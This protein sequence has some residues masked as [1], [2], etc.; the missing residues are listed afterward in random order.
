MAVL[1]ATHLLRVSRVGGGTSIQDRQNIHEH[2][3]NNFTKSKPP[4][5][6]VSPIVSHHCAP[7]CYCHVLLAAGQCNEGLPAMQ[8]TGSA[9]NRPDVF[10]R[11]PMKSIILTV[12]S[13]SIDALRP[14]RANMS[15]QLSMCADCLQEV[16]GGAGQG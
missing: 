1:C 7:Q 4:M 9:K 8:V 10:I 11:D 2:L 13:I 6:S 12:C 16:S 3:K 14:V 5:Y 15:L